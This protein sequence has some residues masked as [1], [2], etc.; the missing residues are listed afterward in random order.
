MAKGLDL[1]PDASNIFLRLGPARH[2]AR[3][4]LA[5]GSV[6]AHYTA[7]RP[8]LD[9]MLTTEPLQRR[10]RYAQCLLQAQAGFVRAGRGLMN[11]YIMKGNETRGKRAAVAPSGG[12]RG[13]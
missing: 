12:R 11:E 4:Q 3:F 8:A 5:D 7:V 2:Q 10:S 6:D 1:S 9:P 13:G